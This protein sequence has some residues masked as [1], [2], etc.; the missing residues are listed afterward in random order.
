[1]MP[2]AKPSAMIELWSINRWLRWTGIRLAVEVDILG[3]GLPT[4]GPTRIGLVWWGWKDLLSS[5]KPSA[6]QLLPLMS[7]SD[8]DTPDPLDHF[9]LNLAP[10]Q[11]ALPPAEGQVK[12]RLK[13]LLGSQEPR[14]ASPAPL[15]SYDSP[16]P[17][18][19]ATSSCLHLVKGEFR[20]WCQG[21]LHCA[22][23][24]DKDSW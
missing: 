9:K 18:R 4:R 14:A 20:T 15:R 3:A 2:K 12:S 21:C 23:V 19:P 6:G 7:G 13:R 24:P 1:M 17:L 16:T 10:L 22:S 8:E 11:A 5:A